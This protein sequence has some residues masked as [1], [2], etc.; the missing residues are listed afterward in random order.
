MQVLAF[1]LPLVIAYEI[2]LVSVLHFGPQRLNIQA[3]ET[4]LRFFDAFGIHA[5]GFSLP[6]I[7]L[8]VVLLVWH[9]LAREAWRIDGPALGWML[10]ESIVLAVPLV[11]FGQIMARGG[12]D[13]AAL[14]T[15]P[16]STGHLGE[17]GLAA[18]LAVAIGAGLYEELIFRMLVIAVLHTVLVD[19]ARMPPAWG[20]ALS[21]A[22]SAIL[23]TAYHSGLTATRTAFLL[24]AGLYFG[25]IFLLRGFGIVVA[26][27]TIYDVV[28]ITLLQ[29]DA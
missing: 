2:A 20:A 13:L 29:P 25:A 21:V 5:G 24:V 19:F 6:G 16:D 7:L 3:H 11:V 28:T 9:V 27:H 18:Q 10:L 14:A 17:L 23:F 22:F 26:V 8:V 4:L 15:A 1:L 12:F